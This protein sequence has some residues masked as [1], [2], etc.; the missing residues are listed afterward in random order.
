MEIFLIVIEVV[1]EITITNIEV[2][3]FTNISCKVISTEHF[4]VM[5]PFETLRSAFLSP[6]IY[7]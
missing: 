2:E 3:S 1:D 4:K 7:F 6:Y 5:N